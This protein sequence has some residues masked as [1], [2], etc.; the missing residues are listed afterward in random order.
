VTF[1]VFGATD[2][3][4]QFTAGSLN[5]AYPFDE[6][7]GSLP[8]RLGVVP[9]QALELVEWEARAF[10]TFNIEAPLTVEELTRIIV[11]VFDS[12]LGCAGVAHDI[13]AE[14]VELESE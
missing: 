9:L 5:L 3:W 4:V 1:E 6:N 2:R 14:I 13:K 10:A 12:T 7:P 8:A 11:A